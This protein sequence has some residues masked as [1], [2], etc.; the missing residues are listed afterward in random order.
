MTF[1]VMTES[2]LY[3][4][5]C[6]DWLIAE[7]EKDGIVAAALSPLDVGMAAT[8]HVSR[9]VRVPQWKRDWENW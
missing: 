4:T 8:V 9:S 6:A 7:I 2:I 1:S 3:D 5:N